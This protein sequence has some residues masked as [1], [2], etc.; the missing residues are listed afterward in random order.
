MGFRFMELPCRLPLLLGGAAGLPPTE[1]GMPA[2]ACPEL[3]ALEHPQAVLELQRRY[4]LAGCSVLYAPTAGASRARLAAYGLAGQVQELNRRLV[5]LTREAAGAVPK[6]RCWIAGALSPT[7][8]R[9]ESPSEAPFDQWVDI[10]SEQAAALKEA[11]VD[12]LACEA[13]TSLSEARAALLAARRTGLPVLVSLEVNDEGE[14]PSGAHF[15]PAVITLQ[16]LGA[17]AVGLDG[18]CGPAGMQ[19]P[20]SEALPHALVPLA[21]RPNTAA[22]DGSPLSPLQFGRAMAPLLD[23]G[24]AV[25]GGGPAATPEHL[26]VLRG[27]ADEHPTVAPREIDTDACAVESEALFLSDDLEYGAPIPCDS[28]LADRLIEAE[29]E[30]NAALVELSQPGD[31]DN[32]LDYGGMSRLPILLHADEA[33]LLD[34]AL[35]RFPGRLLVDS[36]CEIERPLLEDIAARYGALVF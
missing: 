17:A 14:A 28:D 18:P 20:L 29:E 35:R 4:I 27:I 3:W 36:L 11:G 34:E 12:L 31:I 9:G 5:S 7:G 24:A 32:L 1:A 30:G 8:L 22:E 10:F 23:A 16:A 26:A 25:I 19:E 13:M 6:S 33:L 21:V 15:L 2:G